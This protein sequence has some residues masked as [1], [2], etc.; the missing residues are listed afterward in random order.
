MR[1][2]LRGIVAVVFGLDGAIHLL[3][4]LGVAA[5]WRIPGEA[6]RFFK[7]E[8]SLFIGIAYLI[9]AIGI[10]RRKRLARGAAAGLAAANFAGAIFT[11]SVIP[12]TVSALFLAV[13][14]FVLVWVGWPSVRAEFAVTRESAE[15]T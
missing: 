4:I 13:W 5:K 12:V 2:L 6:D 14:L 1:K 15:A 9:V 7:A 11:M 10:Y 8:W 3:R